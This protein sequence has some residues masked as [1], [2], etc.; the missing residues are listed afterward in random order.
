MAGRKA[1]GRL[2]R[3][4]LPD[5]ADWILKVVQGACKACAPQLKIDQTHRATHIELQLPYLLDIS[6]FES[7]LTQGTAPA[8]PGLDELSTALRVV[9][10]G[11]ERSWVARLRTGETTHWVL[12]KGGEASLE[13]VVEAAG[14]PQVTQ[15]LIGIAFPPGQPG[16][17]GGLRF[18]AAIQN[19]HEALA[20]RA[21][22]CPIP[23]LLDGRRLDTLQR[24]PILGSLEKELF[25]GVALGARPELTPIAAPSGLEQGPGSGWS[26]GFLDQCPLHLS[27]GPRHGSSIL[28]MAYHYLQEPHTRHGKFHTYRPVPAA[29]RVLLV[30][31]GVVVGKRNIGL[32]EPLAFDVHLNADQAR[33]DLS[34]L[35]VSVT[36][37][38][39]EVARAEMGSLGPFLDKVGAMLEHHVSRPR[40][41]DLL[42]YGGVSGVALVAA[43][44]P[45]K[46]LAV[47]ASAF[48]LKWLAQQ[49]QLLIQDCLTEVSLHKQ[50][51]GPQSGN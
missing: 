39:V 1:A 20:Q 40:P 12:V 21:R 8:Q 18:G 9:G 46:L 7:S 4:L 41:R 26:D 43:P 23:L 51:F 48:R 35:E 32:L 2:A 10:L 29:S 15:V 34:G 38:E 17:L 49:H 28:R 22:A 24:E 36:E 11:Q 44:W 13:T 3:S 16:K 27:L 14:Q 25:L 30:R 5:P 19:E 45:L 6:A 33:A 37:D 50:R 47:G 42:L 31:H